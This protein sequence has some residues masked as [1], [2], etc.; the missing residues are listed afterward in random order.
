MLIFSN[1]LELLVFI[2]NSFKKCY[3]YHYI[4]IVII[5]IIFK[6]SY[7]Y[8]YIVIVIIVIIFGIIVSVVFLKVL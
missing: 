3:S 4:V 8:H 2:Y 7:S 5:V 6:K 1:N